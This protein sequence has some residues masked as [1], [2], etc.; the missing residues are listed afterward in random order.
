M[1]QQLHYYDQ[2]QFFNRRQ[3]KTVERIG[4][5]I[6]PGD[7][8][9]PSFSQTGCI[10]YIDQLMEVSEPADVRDLAL[11]MTLVSFVPSFAI[12]RLLLLIQQQH[13][14][15]NFIGGPMRLL[16]IALQGVV[17]SLYYS[18][19]TAENYQGTKVFDVIDYHVNCR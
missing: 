18:N 8:L 2:S 7:S 9:F 16:Q 11:L 13:R 5:L 6:I 3:L 14:L 1:S 10:Q 19:K 4:D 17:M 15:P 12:H